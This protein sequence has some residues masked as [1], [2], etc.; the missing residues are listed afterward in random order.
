METPEPAAEVETE[1]DLEQIRAILPH[2]YPFLLIDRVIKV[3]AHKRAVGLKAVTIDEPYFRG[4]PQGRLAMP[5]VLILEA[6]AQTAAVAAAVVL[7]VGTADKQLV[8]LGMQNVQFH[9]PVRPGELLELHMV[10]ERSHGP[11]SKMRGEAKVAGRLVAEARLTAM[12][13]D[14]GMVF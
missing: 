2:R 13:L 12:Q 3:V 6:M 9:G 1:F 14:V 5:G 4:Q 11:I 10:K 8:L 7:G